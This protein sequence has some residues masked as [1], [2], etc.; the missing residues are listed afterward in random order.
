MTLFNRILYTLF[1]FVSFVALSA[2]KQAK[3]PNEFFLLNAVKN[4]SMP[5]IKYALDTLKVSPN[6]TDQDGI[7]VLIY[8]V[9]NQNQ[10]AVELLHKRGAKVRYRIKTERGNG[11]G[12]NG[13]RMILLQHKSALDFAINKHNLGLVK[14]LI[15]MGAELN[16][17]EESL[18]PFAE[19]TE[20]NDYVILYYLLER[21]AKV[22]KKSMQHMMQYA[23]MRINMQ[24][25]IN[26]IRSNSYNKKKDD[27]YMDMR[28]IQFWEQQG[29]EFSEENLID[30]E[31]KRK[32]HMYS[33]ISD[34]KQTIARYDIW[35]K[36]HDV[37]VIPDIDFDGII[38]K[39]ILKREIKQNEKSEQGPQIIERDTDADKLIREAQRRVAEEKEKESLQISE[40]EKSDS[41]FT[42]FVFMMI[43][44]FI[45]ILAV[46]IKY[47]SIEWHVWVNLFK[48]LFAFQQAP[49]PPFN[50]PVN[51]TNTTTQKPIW[52]SNYNANQ[53]TR[54][55]S[56]VRKKATVPKAKVNVSI[57]DLRGW[58]DDNTI[59]ISVEYLTIEDRINPIRLCNQHEKE[60]RR[61]MWYM[62]RLE[63]YPDD[64]IEQVLGGSGLLPRLNTLWKSINPSY[65]RSVYKRSLFLLVE[66]YALRDD[67]VLSFLNKM[68]KEVIEDKGKNKKTTKSKKGQKRKK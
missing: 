63:E 28:V 48:R 31:T 27:A 43:V 68:T 50:S 29:F 26:S 66:N 5:G 61:M 52:S 45:V 30:A 3:N 14:T 56:P 36:D 49:A 42:G 15:D 57:Y 32:T 53:Y 67:R 11:D 21:G 24:S 62:R 59:H 54:T 64:K 6:I 35:K 8:A 25:S 1:F 60:V 47:G 41:K 22:P 34:I 20:A 9:G 17:K 19:A 33:T 44:A 7:S 4:D 39:E 10:E 65:V 13:L 38:E 2:A 18:S 16:P 58:K 40:T 23:I 51:N 37:T 55:S 12:T 46:Y